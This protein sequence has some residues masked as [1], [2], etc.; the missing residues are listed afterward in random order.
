MDVLGSDKKALRASMAAS[1]AALSPAQAELAAR[2]AQER[3]W[4][5]RR[6]REAETVAL[7]MAFRAETSAALLLERAWAE[8]KRALLPRCPRCGPEGARVM[9]F[10][11]VRCLEELC[12]GAY[13]ILAPDPGRCPTETACVPDLLV[14]PGLAFDR[15]GY[16]LGYGGGYY[17]RYL[18]R[19]ELRGTFCVG[20]CFA[21]QLID[22]LPHD[23]WDR[24]LH[25][26][27]TEEETLCP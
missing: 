1:R 24:R 27:C 21:V 9:E 23:P 7:Y 25:C 11:P 6:W 14:A 16:R 5:L 22:E 18:A 17:D 13:G 4:G 10:A 26:V 19:P 20:L 12:P 3:V 15:Q 8:G 2:A